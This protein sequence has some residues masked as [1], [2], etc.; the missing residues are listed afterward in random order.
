MSDARALKVIGHV[1]ELL[2]WFWLRKAQDEV[3]V[4]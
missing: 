2:S 1:I 4:V 3:D